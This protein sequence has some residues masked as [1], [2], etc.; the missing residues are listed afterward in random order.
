MSF[1]HLHVHTEFSMLD[2]LSNINKLV[3]RA[4]DLGM[5]SLGITDHGGM[6]GVVDFYIACKA[7]GIKPIIGCE[8]Y[9]APGLHTDRSPMDKTPFHLTVLAQ[10]NVGYKNLMKLVTKSN[11]EGFYYKPR[12]S[13]DLLAEHADGLVVLSGCPS[14]EMSRLIIDG[15][16]KEAEELVR[17]YQASV[18]NFYLEIQRHSNL[19][20]LGDLNDGLVKIAERMDIPLVATNDLHYVNQEDAR[21]QDVMVCVQTNTTVNDENRMKMSDESYYLKGPSEMAAMFAD[22]PD[23]LANT[24]KIAELC[25]TT[26]DFSTLHLPQYDVPA[27]EDADDYLG[28]LCWQGFTQRYPD[29]GTEDAKTRLGYELDVIKTTQYPNYFLVVWDIADFARKND[30][31]F[32]V[33]GSA[34]SSLALYCLGI[35]EIDPMEFRLVFER[36]LNIER[37][38]MPDIDM[39]F[40]DDRREE[41]IKYVTKKYGPGHVAQIISFGTMGAKASIRDSGRALGIPL[42]DADRLARLIPTKLGITLQ[43]AWDE[44]PELQAAVNADPG[45]RRLFDTARG[46][47]GVVRHSST[48]AAAVVISQ[49]PLVDHVPLQRPT[50]GDESGVAMTQYPMGPVAKLGLLKMDFLGLINYSILSNALK[51]I[52]KHQGIELKLSDVKF[53]DHATYD[54]L[55]SAETAS[56][57]QLESAG[58][59]RH[60]KELKPGSLAELAAMVALYRPGPMEHIGRFID[61][62]FGKVPIEYPHPAL[63]EILEETYGVIVYQDQVLHI[64]RKFAGYTLGSADI[65]RKAMGKKDANLMAQERAKFLAGAKQLSYDNVIAGQVFDLIEPFA[66]YAFNKAH[67]V[68]YA[69]VA[70]WTAYFKANYPVEYMTCVLNAYEGNAEKMA[71]TIAECARLDIPILAPSVNHSE[72]RFSIDTLPDNKRAIRFGLGNIKGVGDQA[73]EELVNERVESGPFTTLEDFGRRAGSSAANRRVIEALAKVG[74]LDMFG[75]R[76]SLLA[77]VDSITHLLQSEAKLKDSGQST[78]FD[79]FGASVPTPLADIELVD[80]PELSAREV[81]LWE[82]DLLGVSLTTRVL[83]PL[84][85][86]DGAILSREQLN[87]IPENEKVMLVGMVTGVRLQSD[88]NQRRIAFVALEI[89]DGSTVD[90]AVWSRTYEQTASLWVD[91]SLVQMKGPVRFRND[92]RSVHCDE[93]IAYELPEGADQLPAPLSVHEPKVEQWPAPTSVHSNGLAVGPITSTL[94]AQSALV[95]DQVSVQALTAPSIVASPPSIPTPAASESHAGG[96]RPS[97]APNGPSPINAGQLYVGPPSTSALPNSGMPTQPTR[98]KLLINMTETD[99]PD[100]DQMLLREVLQT[101]LD[102]PGTDAVDLLITSEGRNW[103]L[104]MPI[105]TTGFCPALETR[106]YDLLGRADAITIADAALIAVG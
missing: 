18:P 36:F 37:K 55:A 62:K 84:H 90:V 101:L 22:L 103:R 21:F 92:E 91:S 1:T 42:A 79:L 27:G 5:D 33:R 6:Y 81:A 68:C 4:Q 50:K 99:R 25:E 14:A 47:E 39:D 93:A 86:P 74:A 94:A 7:A 58:M 52:K 32:G 56:V 88:K 100:E 17:W 80:A 98:R 51:L 49:E 95:A 3:K 34:A 38:E 13:K 67:S 28:K 78:M 64:L 89:F 44:T 43:D 12:I 63:E 61:S 104:E 73:V 97:P 35:T 8:L 16:I 106:I 45:L 19:P 96:L 82:R 53:D 48:H 60:I 77:S 41:A 29:G 69:V 26:L 105:I 40:Q 57:F 54:L 11:L 10:N 65:V 75:K 46:L 70:Y 102:Y 87:E 24:Q 9:V 76:A 31:V 59:R 20:F 30:I 66:G 72:V 71:A 85:A 2:G 23:A 83:D 15:N